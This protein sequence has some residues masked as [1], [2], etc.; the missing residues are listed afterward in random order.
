MAGVEFGMDPSKLVE[1]MMRG[2][3]MQ[4]EDG[5]QKLKKDLADGPEKK[6]KR[7]AATTRKKTDATQITRFADHYCDWADDAFGEAPKEVE[8]K[9]KKD[10][11]W[12]KNFPWDDEVEMANKEVFGN[13]DFRE[14]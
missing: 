2:T 14:N 12:L 13:Q 1:S 11:P 6:E 9:K 3:K 10:S 8:T 5:G 4:P 7:K